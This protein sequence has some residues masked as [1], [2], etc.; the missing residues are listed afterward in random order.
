MK[1]AGVQYL[2]KRLNINLQE[3]VWGKI[4]AEVDTAIGKLPLNTSQQKSVRNKYAEASAQLRMVKDAWR[5]NVM[6]PKE[7]YT[8]EEAERIFRNVK[9][10]MV[11]LGSKI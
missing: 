9:D 1:V 11:Y 5:N 4:L 3:K 7:T 6:H 10:F 2:G 8:E